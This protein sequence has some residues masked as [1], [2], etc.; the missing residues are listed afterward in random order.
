[1]SGLIYS[2]LTEIT[3]YNDKRFQ[4]TSNEFGFDLLK[5]L[6]VQCVDTMDS[7]GEKSWNFLCNGK[8]KKEKTSILMVFYFSFQHVNQGWI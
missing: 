8:F 2:F 4:F 5:E 6:A 3:E 7:H 1:M